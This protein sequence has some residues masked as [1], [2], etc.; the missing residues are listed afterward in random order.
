MN[1]SDD[2]NIADKT[3]YINK[4]IQSNMINRNKDI[5][6]KTIDLLKKTPKTKSLHTLRHSFGSALVSPPGS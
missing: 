5:D 1:E 2:I 4:T 6:K 3:M